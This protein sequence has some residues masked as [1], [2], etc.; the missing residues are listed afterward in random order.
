MT[1]KNLVNITPLLTDSAIARRWLFVTLALHILLWTLI[2]NFIR[3]ALPM[4]AAEGAV[5]GQSLQLGYDR[6]PWLNA[7]L[8]R[9]AIELGANSDI[10]VYL[11]SQLCVGL[12]FWSVWRLG[13]KML[14]EVQAVVAVLMLEGAQYYTVAAVMFNDNVLELGLWPLLILLFYRAVTLQRKWDWLGVGIVAGLAMMAKYYIALL[15]FPMFLFLLSNAKARKTF[16]KPGIYLALLIFCLIILPHVVWLFQHQGVTL[17]YALNRVDGNQSS[18][19]QD[20]QSVLK[21]AVMQLATFLIPIL[22]FSFTLGRRKKVATPSLIKPAVNTHEEHFNKAF[23]WFVGTGS[24]MITVLLGLVA[25]WKMYVLWGT[26]LL[27]YWGVLLLLYVNP[28][29]TK[30]RFFRFLV[31]VGVI[32]VLILSIYSFSILCSR[33]A[34]SANFPAKVFAQ[35]ITSIWHNRYS[36]PLPYVVGDRVLAS[37]VSR[38]SSDRPHASFSQGHTLVSPWINEQDM[39]RRGAIFITYNRAFSKEI[40][41]EFPSL[42]IVKIV[43]VNYVHATAASQPDQILVGILAPQS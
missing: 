11:F 12:A 6:N 29:I 17:S 26:P 16:K 10:F 38:Y 21:F 5:W 40:L 36:V 33:S 24:Y 35:Q 18:T 41:S 42:K 1:N 7:W 23:L 32:F 14:S 34:T 27:S 28:L 8:T 9:L 19:W 31:A 20:Y 25:G 13:R 4:D 15:L 3:H 2:P 37:Y 22:L 30:T 43:Q 39:R